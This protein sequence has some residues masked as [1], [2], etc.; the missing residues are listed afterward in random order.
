MGKNFPLLHELLNIPYD[1]VPKVGKNVESLA[2]SLG[3]D[4]NQVHFSADESG[5][6]FIKLGS[7]GEE[8]KPMSPAASTTAKDYVNA[9]KED[10]RTSVKPL[11]DSLTK[12]TELGRTLPSLQV[13][14]SPAKPDGKRKAPDALPPPLQANECAFCSLP[15]ASSCS[16]CLTVH[17]CGEYCSRRDWGKHQFACQE[18]PAYL[19]QQD[20]KRIKELEQ[21]RAVQQMILDQMPNARGLVRLQVL[22][23]R[24]PSQY[25]GET[26]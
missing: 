5:A 11:W 23:F 4:T 19:S 9:L 25:E 10:H 13:A 12:A 8:D 6:S 22:L 3:L 20:S 7:F 15:A 26:C 14:P 1:E 2:L 24:P 16:G 21:D 18:S 17:Y